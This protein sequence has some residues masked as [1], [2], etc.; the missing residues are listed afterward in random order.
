[1]RLSYNKD[2]FQNNNKLSIIYQKLIKIELELKEILYPIKQ[3]DF[4][5]DILTALN[6]ACA[7][8]PSHIRAWS[9][10][11]S[12][13]LKTALGSLWCY[14]RDGSALSVDSQNYPNIRYIRHVNDHPGSLESVSDQDLTDLE[15]AVDYIANIIK[16]NLS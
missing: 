11:G 6:R 13:R 3:H 5:H 12:A 15:G 2:A 16:R 7:R 1:M 10:S 14:G 8:K 9:S 4:S